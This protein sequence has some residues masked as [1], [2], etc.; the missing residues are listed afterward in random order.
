MIFSPEINT[1]AKPVTKIIYMKKNTVLQ[2]TEIKECK[3]GVP[4]LS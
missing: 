3:N 2:L 1:V 4:L